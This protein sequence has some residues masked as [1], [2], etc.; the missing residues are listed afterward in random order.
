[1]T[2]AR[3]FLAVIALLGIVAI[4]SSTL[5]GQPGKKAAGAGTTPQ[6]TPAT[7]VSQLAESSESR[8]SAAGVLTYQPVKGDLYFALQLQPKLVPT[9]NRSRGASSS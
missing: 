1:M 4:V 5:Q 2:K 8:F 3:R 9:A 7:Q 6:I